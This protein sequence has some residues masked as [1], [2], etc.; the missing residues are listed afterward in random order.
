MN[1][2]NASGSDS[3]SILSGDVNSEENTEVLAYQGSDDDSSSI[4][5]GDLGS[6]ENFDI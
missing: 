3:S 6:E 2:Y 4:P 1:V 5:S